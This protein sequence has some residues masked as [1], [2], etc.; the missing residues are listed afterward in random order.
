MSIQISPQHHQI[1]LGKNHSNLKAIMQYTKCQIMF[2][3]AQD[4]NIPSL[5]KSNVNISGNIHNV[6]TAR[7][8]LIG[9]LPLLIIFDLP[10]D[11][12]I[13]KIRSE[14]IAEIQTVCDVTINIRQK[15]KQMIKACIIKGIE[16]H[17]SILKLYNTIFFFS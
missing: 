12:S 15:T 10:E 13:L 6:Y 17:A 7:Q 1:V 9:S 14:Q 2:P 4:Q 16:R 5:K 3:D 8:L 11:T